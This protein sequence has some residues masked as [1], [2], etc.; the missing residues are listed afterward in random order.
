MGDYEGTLQIE[1]DDNTMKAKL[2]LTRFANF[3]K[4]KT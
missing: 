2:I 4:G 1:H 3:W